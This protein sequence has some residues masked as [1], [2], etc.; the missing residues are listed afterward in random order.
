V[1]AGKLFGIP[2]AGTHAHS[3]VMNF[4]SEYEAP[5]IDL[6]ALAFEGSDE[7]FVQIA[8]GADDRVGI[9]RFVEHAARLG[10]INKIKLSDNSDKITNPAFKEVFRIYDKESGKAE[11]DLICLKGEEIDERDRSRFSIPRIPGSG[12]PSRIIWCAAFPERSSK[13]ENPSRLRRALPKCARMRREKSKVSGTSI[14]GWIIRIFI[15]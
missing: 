11:A 14:S 12:R 4:P 6:R 3:W 13:A 15:K 2:V 5:Q 7:F 8:R 1:L 10:E 9:A